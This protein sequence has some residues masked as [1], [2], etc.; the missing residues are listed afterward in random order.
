MKNLMFCNSTTDRSILETLLL[1]LYFDETNRTKLT[2]K[3]LRRIF[4]FCFYIFVFFSHFFAIELNSFWQF[5]KAI[6]NPD[7]R[8]NTIGHDFLLKRASDRT[9]PTAKPPASFRP[10]STRHLSHF[11]KDFQWLHFKIRSQIASKFKIL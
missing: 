5:E 9:A 6:P 4:T 3:Y 8:P 7:P 11:W 2:K 10:P 1:L